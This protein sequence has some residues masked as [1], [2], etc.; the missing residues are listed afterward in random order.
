MRTARLNGSQALTLAADIGGDPAQPPVLLLHGGGQTRHAW[1]RA[2]RQLVANGYHVISY[3]ARGHG[4]SDWSPAGDYQTEALVADLE[5]VLAALSRPA[6]LV[7]ASMGGITSLIAVGRR[8][9]PPVT[10][11]VMVDV[12][13]TLERRGIEHIRRFMTARPDGFGSLE[14]VADAVAAY[15]PDRPRPRDASGLMKNLRRGDDGRLYWHWDPRII[16]DSRAEHVAYLEA[17]EARMEDAAR[18]V[19]VPTLLVRGSHSDVVSPAGAQRFRELIP[20]AEVVDVQ[21][22]G[23]MVAGDRN[24]A[25]NAAVLEFL[26]RHHR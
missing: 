16:A 14:E 15:N 8:D 21:G 5:V 23:H 2:F 25:F 10:A 9:P 24:D 7:G 19:R 17:Y 18:Q 4:D 26:V 12:A 3:D 22:A 13:P 20:Q 1:G 6:A 11:L